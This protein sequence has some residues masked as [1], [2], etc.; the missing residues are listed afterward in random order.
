[1]AR[2][3]ATPTEV[4]VLGGGPAGLQAALRAATLGASTTLISAGPIG[5]MAAGDGPVPVRAMAAAARLARESRLLDRYGI[6]SVEPEVDYPRLLSR[7]AA[8]RDEHFGGEPSFD[9]INWDATDG[10]LGDN[11]RAALAVLRR[12]DIHAW[13]RGF[14]ERLEAAARA[15]DSGLATAP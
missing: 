14:I 8:V 15:T 1:M 2:A 10:T 3:V 9:A 6:A 4:L 5:G 11:A 12:N 7:V 13:R